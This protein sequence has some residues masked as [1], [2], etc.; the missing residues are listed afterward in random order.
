MI[1]KGK[2]GRKNEGRKEGRR[3]RR[4]RRRGRRRKSW[5]TLLLQSMMKKNYT[6]QTSYLQRPKIIIGI[7]DEETD[8]EPT[9][10]SI[11]PLHSW[12]VARANCQR[13]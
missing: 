1:K 11:L 5:W 2:E 3:R 4:K 13:G 8:L 9:C 6:Q 10:P 12:L 7:K